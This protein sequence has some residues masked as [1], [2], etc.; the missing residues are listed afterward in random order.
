MKIQAKID[1]ACRALLELSKHWPNQSPLQ[2]GDIAERQ[3]LP[4]KFLI[5]LL[6]MLKQFGYV[7][8]IRGQKGGYI[9]AKPPKEIRLSEILRNLSNDKDLQQS[10]YLSRSQDVFKSIWQEADQAAFKILSAITFEDIIKREQ[11]LS[12]VPV[13]TI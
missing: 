13:Y 9:L 8:S 5:Q 7:Q 1:Y 12:K 2:V 11:V 6:I 4:I 10:G 3:R